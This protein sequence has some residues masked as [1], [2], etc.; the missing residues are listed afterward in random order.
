MINGKSMKY[1]SALVQNIFYTKIFADRCSYS[2]GVGCGALRVGLVLELCGVGV[3]WKWLG[4]VQE[5]C[6]AVQGFPTYQ[7]TL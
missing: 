6:G 5:W 3:V 4:V 2:G 7:G 1:N